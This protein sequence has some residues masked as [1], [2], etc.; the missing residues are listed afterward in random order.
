MLAK[1]WSQMKQGGYADRM[2]ETPKLVASTT[3]DEPLESN[4]SL[5][6]GDVAEAGSELKRQPGQDISMYGSPELTQTLMRH[7]LIDEY[8]IWVHPARRRPRERLF[9][10]GSDQATLDLVEARRLGSGGVILIYR[11]SG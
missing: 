4:A 8:R 3:L 7:D 9:D 2:N 1:S 10:D 5:I 6:K 11:P